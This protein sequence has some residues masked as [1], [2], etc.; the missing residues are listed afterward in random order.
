MASS[1]PL[2]RWTLIARAVDGNQP[3]SREH[4][5]E[6]LE[7]YW[8]PMFIHLKCKGMKHAQ[9]EDLLQDFVLTLLDRNLL[10]VADP[11]KGK[12]RSLL[13]T[14]LDRF[15][16][17]KFRHENAAK[18]SPGHVASLDAAELD[19]AQPPVDGVLAFERA[20]AL[21]VLAETLARMKSECEEG[22]ETV[23]WTLFDERVVRP[24]LGTAEPCDYVE[25]AKR[26]G[27][28][29]EKVAMNMLVT[30]KRQFARV[31]RDVIAE[32]VSRSSRARVDARI[33]T[34]REAAEAVPAADLDLKEHQL[35]AAVEQEISELQR[36]LAASRGVQE[37][38]DELVEHP[39]ADRREPQKSMFFRMLA[40]GPKESSESLESL[41]NTG[42]ETT[43]DALAVGLNEFLGAPLSRVPGL[44]TDHW[45]TLGEFLTGEAPDARRLA[46]VKDWASAHRISR[47]GT[48]PPALANALYFVVLAAAITRGHRELTKL[49]ETQLIAGLESLEQ[50][51]W[52]PAE[53]LP[54]V[55]EARRAIESRP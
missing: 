34:G 5:G 27:L 48:V 26:H 39:Q 24:L 11:S 29:N 33:G 22:D 20:W 8:R 46:A 1:F 14:A 30:A 12:F 43:D 7:Q 28:E 17:S 42:M 44:E 6:L 37:L 35:R 40:H 45:L 15:L 9:A 4:M 32:Y 55:R 25:F 54:M 23:R 52:F 51:T 3:A 49:G 21:D 38:S 16:V 47:S 18:R 19:V 13:L 31:M 50:L 2:T 10:S 41:L 36:I 53:L